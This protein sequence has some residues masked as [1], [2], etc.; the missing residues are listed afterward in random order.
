M[1]THAH[2]EG[3][4]PPTFHRR[5]F[6]R[7]P[8]L[9]LASL[10]LSTTALLSACGGSDDE[11]SLR[12]LTSWAASH[13]VRE[14]P[15]GLPDSTVRMIVRPTV[16]GDSLRVRLENTVG[17]APVTFSSAYVGVAGSAA[18]VMADTNLRLTF[19]GKENLT[20]APGEQAW[21]D[22]VNMRVQ[23]FQRLAVSLY[24]ASASDVSSHSLGLA[25]NY[26]ARGNQAA[27]VSG[28][29][30]IPVNPI[31]QGT[32]ILAFPVY[33]VGAVDVLSP[34]PATVVTLGDSITDGR[35]STTT[36]GGVLGGGVVVPDVYQRWTDILADRL[37][38]LAPDQR[39]AVANAGIAGNRVVSGGNGPPALARLDRDVLALSGVSHVIFFEGTNDI[40]GGASAATVIAG[41]QQVID[42][43]RA[44]KIK[45]IGVTAIPRGQTGSAGFNAVQEQIRL[46]VNS[47][48]R[49]PGRFDGVLDFDAVMAGGGKSPTGAEII[50]PEYNCDN[51]HPNAAGYAAL[52]NSINLDLFRN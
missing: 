15:A 41:M 14:T 48:I 35:C 29:G 17:T 7:R 45:I 36:N 50:K 18:G 1:T 47:W 19:D 31:A 26:M 46:E 20:L 2:R 8:F 44:G 22:P 4:A 37:A 42:R 23:A 52:G 30:F 24:V 39:K 49:T 5:A 38:A 33:W 43:V 51:I 3:S 27:A 10:A 34:A 6:S 25:T 32:S 13:N 11:A 9:L 40:S 12:W 28:T 21:S 16:S